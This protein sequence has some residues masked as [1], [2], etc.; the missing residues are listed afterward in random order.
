MP[1]IQLI[2]P[3][4]LNWIDYL[5]EI[6]KDWRFTAGPYPKPEDKPDVM[7]FMWCDQRTIDF[8]N[9]NPKISKYIVFVRAYE[10]AQYDIGSLDWNRV[11]KVLAVNDAIAEIVE[12]MIKRKLEVVYNGVPLEKWTF[13]E[14]G[15]GN[16]IA[17][18]AALHYK[19]NH[20]LAMQIFSQLPEDYELHCVGEMQCLDV[21]YYLQRLGKEFKREILR[22]SPIPANEM[23]DWLED[24]DYI[25]STSMREG[26]PNNIIEA[27]A[28]GIKRIIHN[29]P[30]SKKQF[31]NLV[32]NHIEEAVGMIEP[33]SPYNSRA[34]RDL[35]QEKFSMKNYERIKEI[36]TN[37]Y[38]GDLKEDN[39]EFWDRYEG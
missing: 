3:F 37:L 2:S 34:Y 36:A 30:G 20:A 28:K 10:Y 27:M 1:H 31:G 39:P 24:K 35:V 16:K 38:N 5:L 25:L 19:K 15:H 4:R 26:C 8:I 7:L 23:N 14:R 9:K 12:V 22:Y 6:F 21:A 11:D 32:F 18:V 33:S 29:W 13:N 17:M